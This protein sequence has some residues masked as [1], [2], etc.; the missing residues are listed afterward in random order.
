MKLE[1]NTPVELKEV[2]LVFD[3]NL[4]RFNLERIAQECVK[5]F[6]LEADG[7]EIFRKDDNTQRFVRCKL[8]APLTVSEL[9][10]KITGT[11]GDNNARVVAVRCF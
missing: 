4:D 6:T 1:W 10:L 11:N 7:R 9:V 8:P 2:D 3:T 5:S